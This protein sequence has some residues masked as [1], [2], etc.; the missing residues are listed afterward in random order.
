MVD[1]GIR[2]A[3]V[4][5]EL[6]LIKDIK[7][8]KKSCFK[9]I[10]KKRKMITEDKEMLTSQKEKA[11]SNWLNLLQHVSSASWEEHVMIEALN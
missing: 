7:N 1:M 11:A 5:N 6:S 3:K 4:L 10:P 9:S 2:A 8:S